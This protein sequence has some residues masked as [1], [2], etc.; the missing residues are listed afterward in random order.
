MVRQAL[1]GIAMGGRRE[2]LQRLKA[3]L[4][5][6]ARAVEGG[7]GGAGLVDGSEQCRNPVGRVGMAS[8]PM[9]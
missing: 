5:E 3:F 1:Q 8:L 9:W 4:N 2:C 7:L 6:G